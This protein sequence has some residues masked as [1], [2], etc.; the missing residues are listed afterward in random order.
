[1]SYVQP[2]NFEV[3][4]LFY[5]SMGL[6]YH[7]VFV[8]GRDL[9]VTLHKFKFMLTN[10]DRRI[11]MISLLNFLDRRSKGSASFYEIKNLQT[12]A[13]YIVPFILSETE[14]NLLSSL[15]LRVRSMKVEF[16]FTQKLTLLFFKVTY[17]DQ[18]GNVF[19]FHFQ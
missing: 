4:C 6:F 16:V 19:I 1:M 2:V 10:C 11:H 13:C 9:L 7:N 8:N 14:V 17:F 5:G 18:N 12:M 3:N 15:W